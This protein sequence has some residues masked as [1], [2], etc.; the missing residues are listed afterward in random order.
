MICNN[1][2][3]LSNKSTSSWQKYQDKFL[4]EFMH[5]AKQQVKVDC[6]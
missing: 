1:K 2:D 4:P 6:V 3:K 5:M